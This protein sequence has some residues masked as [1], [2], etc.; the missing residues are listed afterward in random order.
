MHPPRSG[1]HNAAR[2]NPRDRDSGGTSSALPSGGR[3]IQRPMPEDRQRHRDA[4][5]GGF[6]PLPLESGHATDA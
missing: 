5:G 1:L 4:S 6:V 3:G 2:P